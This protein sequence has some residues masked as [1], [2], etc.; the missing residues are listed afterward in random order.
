MREEEDTFI[1][2]KGEL[3]LVK[4]NGTRLLLSIETHDAI[5][6]LRDPY[7]EP[8]NNIYGRIHWYLGTDTIEQK[9]KGQIRHKFLVKIGIPFMIKDQIPVEKLYYLSNR[10]AIEYRYYDENFILLSTAYAGIYNSYYS[11]MERIHP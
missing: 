3:Y 6:Y 9:V 1:K 4:S 11:E 5:V 2:Q 8:T 7:F 10:G